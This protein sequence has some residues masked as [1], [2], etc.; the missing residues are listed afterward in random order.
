[1]QLWPLAKLRHH[2]DLCRGMPKPSKGF[3]VL[4]TTGA[5][6]P[7]HKG[8]VQM[9]H[10]AR[11]RLESEGFAVIGAWLSPSHDGYVQPKAS[12]LRT[13]GLSSAFR[14]E[15]A[16]RATEE[17]EI[18]AVGSW[19]AS[20]PG[21]WP[22]FPVVAEALQHELRRH[23]EGQGVRVFYVCGSDHFR[24]CG[25]HL[26]MRSGIGIVAVPRS[27]ATGIACESS[28]RE[29]PDK[30]V[31][32]A[33]PASGEIA[34]YSSTK[35]RKALND[36]DHDFVR[37]AISERASNLLFCPA[38]EEVSQFKADYAKLG[39]LHAVEASHDNVL[40]NSTANEDSMQNS[41]IQDKQ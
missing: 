10:Q 36:L 27:A 13:P 32:L 30:L 35:V 12:S 33:K 18:V 31:Y 25:L 22:D 37:E 24:N 19:E 41:R 3:A 15:L 2:R 34:S 40:A 39:L 11:E 26:G 1:M 23:P 21:S 9:L 5:M 29:H 6:N 17:D 28:G 7:V 38:L 8:H 14:L 20:Q 16:Q 4:L